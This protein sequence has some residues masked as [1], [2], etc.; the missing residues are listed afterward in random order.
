ML[1][2]LHIRL[3]ASLVVLFLVIGIA[4]VL[5]TRY[6][7]ERHHLEVTQRLNA[8]IAMYVAQGAALIRD[9]EPNTAAL[10]ALAHHAM[11]INPTVEVYLLDTQGRILGHD[12]GNQTG[13]RRDVDLQPIKTL[14]NGDAELPLFGDDPRNPQASKIFSA[15]EVRDGDVHEGYVYVVLGGLRHDQLSEEI[16]GSDALRAATMAVVACLVFGLASALLIF[17]RLSRR[18]KALTKRTNAYCAETLTDRACKR[19]TVHA[20]GDEIEQLSRAFAAMQERIDVQLTE[21]RRTDHQRRDLVAQVS[22]DLRTP[23]TTMRGYIE[24]LALLN[25][26]AAA[27]ENRRHIDTVHRHLRRME[28]LVD[29]LFELARLDAGLVKPNLDVACVAEL[30]AD[31]CQA[32]RDAAARKAIDLQVH[33]AGNDTRALIDMRLL[34]RVITNLLE[35]AL[36]HTPTGGR[37]TVTVAGGDDSVAVSVAD[38]GSGITSDHLTQLFER[39]FSREPAAQGD[40]SSGLGLAI[41]RHILELHDAPID[42]VS[43]PGRGSRFEF[44]LQ[45]IRQAG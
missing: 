1:R 43:T 9:G 11:V 39:G 16:G 2:T 35:N 17:A 30:T 42:V 23:L 28:H 21:I 38:T 13:L 8:P 4:L 20:A 22:H 15:A 19:A 36:R 18:L 41:V 6:A 32:F 3:S 45:P 33:R 34:E 5:L 29:D 25:G 31:V 26:D 27:A 10:K 14:L 40:R 12:L 24:T 44:R 37:I 7:S